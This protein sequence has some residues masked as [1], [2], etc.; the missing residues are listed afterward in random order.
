[1]GQWALRESYVLFFGLV[2]GVA[3]AIG[4]RVVRRR[5]HLYL[6]IGVV[7]GAGV[8]STI[9]VGLTQGGASSPMAGRCLLD[10]VIAL[11]SAAL[12]MILMP[13]AESATRITTDL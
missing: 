6:T 13:M 10:L 5:R 4:I 3:G 9:A 12:A 7:A 11:A 2:G 8:L 1:D